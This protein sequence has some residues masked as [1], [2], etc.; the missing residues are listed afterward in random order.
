MN[1]YEETVTSS[2]G[3]VSGQSQQP[4]F[5]KDERGANEETG[6]DGQ[7]QAD[8][9]VLHLLGCGFTIKWILCCVG[10]Q[11]R[12]VGEVGYRA[13]WEHLEEHVDTEWVTERPKRLLLFSSFLLY[14]DFF[15]LLKLQR[16]GL[17]AKKYYI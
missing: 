8:V 13:I 14:F 2:G 3:G 4:Q 6:K 16:P 9:E 12:Y 10:V 11:Y 1:G 15:L 5:L 17:F 7:E